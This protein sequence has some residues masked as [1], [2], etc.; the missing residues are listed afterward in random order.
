MPGSM[1]FFVIILENS[2]TVNFIYVFLFNKV[3]PP[4]Q[5]IDR[6]GKIRYIDFATHLDI[7]YVYIYIYSKN[8]IY[9]DLLK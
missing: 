9:L 3:L 8:Y 2:S 1:P 4:L 5:I 7:H 6:F